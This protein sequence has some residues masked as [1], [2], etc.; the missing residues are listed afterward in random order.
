M[1][2]LSYRNQ[3]QENLAQYNMQDQ[4]HFIWTPLVICQ[5]AGYKGQ[6]RHYQQ[7]IVP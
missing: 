1:A 3:D 6:C 7:K 4:Q 2:Q 5:K